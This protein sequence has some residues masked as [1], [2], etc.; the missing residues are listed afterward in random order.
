[1]LHKRKDR[2]SLS[3][4]VNKYKHRVRKHPAHSPIEAA[5]TAPKARASGPPMD[6]NLS[7]G[8]QTAK[9]DKPPTI[10]ALSSYQA[11]LMMTGPPKKH[12]GAI[13]A[14]RSAVCPIHAS[15]FVPKPFLRE[16]LE[17]K[18]ITRGERRAAIVLPAVINIEP[19][20]YIIEDDDDDDDDDDDSDYDDD[21]DDDDNDDDEEE[22]S[23]EK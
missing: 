3:T 2:D 19:A 10:P 11:A 1:M 21:D 6:K 7:L 4:V 23:V 15:C 18:A 17:T 22:E 14:P 12:I 16:L 9:V 13:T 8:A 5:N 20:T